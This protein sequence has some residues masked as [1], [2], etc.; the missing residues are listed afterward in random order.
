MRM[1]LRLSWKKVLDLKGCGP[2]SINPRPLYLEDE[3]MGVPATRTYCILLGVDHLAFLLDNRC[4]DVVEIELQSEGSSFLS[5]SNTSS[6]Q[7]SKQLVVGNPSFIHNDLPFRLSLTAYGRLADGTLVC[8]QGKENIF[9]EHQSIA[10][11][12]S[13]AATKR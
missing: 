7:V 2:L 9:T 12:S 11:S 13:R 6:F 4:R 10:C 3:T 8:S 1:N 5:H